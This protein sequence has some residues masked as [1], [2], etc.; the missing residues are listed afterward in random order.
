MKRRAPTLK[1]YFQHFQVGQRGMPLKEPNARQKKVIKA[2]LKRVRPLVSP[3][4]ARFG[5]ATARFHAISS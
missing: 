5:P 2:G 4:F 3:F 1:K